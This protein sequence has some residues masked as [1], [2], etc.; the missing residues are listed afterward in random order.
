LQTVLK[1]VKKAIEKRENKKLDY[2]R[3]LKATEHSRA[4][5]NKTERYRQH[6][7]CKF[8]DGVKNHDVDIECR[9]YNVLTRNERDLE[10]ATVVGCHRD[11]GGVDDLTY[12]LTR[13]M[14]PLMIISETKYHARYLL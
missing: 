6:P 12:V 1:P 5:Q 11:Y 14:R 10:K 3:F 7:L 4:K 9:D 13:H 2:E 8:E